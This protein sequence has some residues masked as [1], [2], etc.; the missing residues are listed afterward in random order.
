M[1][2]KYSLYEHCCFDG[3]SKYLDRKGYRMLLKGVDYFLDVHLRKTIERL[4]SCAT[5]QA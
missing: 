5:K 3:T 2:S 1:S 4:Q